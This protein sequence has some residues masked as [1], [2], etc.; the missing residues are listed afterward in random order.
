MDWKLGVAMSS[1]SCRS[2]NAPYV[3]LQLRLTDSTGASRLHTLDMTVPEFQVCV[4]VP[5]CMRMCVR[6][7]VRMCVCACLGAHICVCVCVCVC[8]RAWVHVNECA[9]G[10]VCLCASV[11]LCLFWLSLDC[12]VHVYA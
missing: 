12:W 9:C 5:G 7:C 2:L 10:Y 4:C 1:T 6:V 3:T 11:R 8:V